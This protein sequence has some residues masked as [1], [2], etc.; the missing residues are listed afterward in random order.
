MESIPALVIGAGPAGLAVAA[1][2]TRADVDHVVVEQA[3]ALGWSWRNHYERLHLHTASRTSSL[4]F[5]PFPDA[6][7][8][9]PSRAQVVEYLEAYASAFDIEPRFGRRVTSLSRG[10]RGSFVARFEDG[11]ELAA[12]HVVV[13]SGYNRVP[14]RPAFPGLDNFA[15]S[16]VHS[17]EYREGSGYRGRDVLVVGCGN[18]G[19]EIAL[20]LFEHGARPMLVVRGPVH[21]QPR[22]FLGVNSQEAS[23]RLARFPRV[24]ADTIGRTIGELLYSDLAQ[25]GIERP[26]KGPVSMLVEDGRVPLLDIGTADLIRQGLVRVVPGVQSFEADRASFDDGDTLPVDDVVLATGFTSGLREWVEFADDVLDERELPRS[27]GAQADVAGAFFVGFRNPVTGAL[28]DI[29]AQARRVAEAIR[30][31]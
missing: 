10:G 24:I 3:P 7:S 25:W 31:A 19:G 17:S 8:R 26:K 14:R 29:A 5:M 28:N 2:L 22:E 6:F 21:V 15:G 12:R 30:S 4:P 16:V 9:Y 11:D 13:A 23:L 18:S 20:D 27:H 1:C